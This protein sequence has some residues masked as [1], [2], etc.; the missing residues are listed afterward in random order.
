VLVETGVGQKRTRTPRGGFPNLCGRLVSVMELDGI[1][2]SPDA[3]NDEC[4]KST[5]EKH[6]CEMIANDY[7][8]FYLC[9][10]HFPALSGNMFRM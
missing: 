4:R 10:R 2:Q 8:D 9:D 7:I 1:S 3:M 6:R 5:G